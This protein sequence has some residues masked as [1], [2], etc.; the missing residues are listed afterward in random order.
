M[1][2]HGNIQSRRGSFGGHYCAA[3]NRVGNCCIAGLW[4]RKRDD[5]FPRA[6]SIR[7]QSRRTRQS[8]HVYVYIV[9]LLVRYSARST[10]FSPDFCLPCHNKPLA[11]FSI[12]CTPSSPPFIGSWRAKQTAACIN[13]IPYQHDNSCCS[14]HSPICLRIVLLR[15]CAPEK[16]RWIRSGPMRKFHALFA[17]SSAYINI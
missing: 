8:I 3:L 2:Q 16:A 12:Q 14:F 5:R 15:N 1:A 13:Y 17:K 11:I 4:D 10:F 9:I 7:S 6:G